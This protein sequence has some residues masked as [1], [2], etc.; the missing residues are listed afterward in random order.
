MDWEI[1]K[2]DLKIGNTPK[3]SAERKIIH[4]EF[5]AINNVHHSIE[6]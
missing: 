6:F 3:W 1:L 4:Y 5:E 2:Y